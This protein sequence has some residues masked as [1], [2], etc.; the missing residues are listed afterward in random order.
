MRLF[1]C[2]TILGNDFT[3]HRM[4]G[5]A[6]KI[7]FSGKAFQLIVCFMALTR[8]LVYIFI[9]T[10]NHF[11]VSDA[12]RER[13]REKVIDPPKTDRTPTPAPPYISHHHQ[14]RITTKDRSTQTDPPKIASPQTDCTPPKT[15]PPRPI[16]PKPIHRRSHHPRPIA[17]HRDRITTEDQST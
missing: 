5:C 1:W 3:P 13:E 10:T 12:Q 4:F 11:R 7:K 8:K 14:D 9:F 16:T 2:K 15:D 6:W 17:P